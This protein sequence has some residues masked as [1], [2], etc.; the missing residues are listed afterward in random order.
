MN[1]FN[2]WLLI[3]NI[4]KKKPKPPWLWE[5]ASLARIFFPIFIP[6]CS[7]LDG[8]RPKHTVGNGTNQLSLHK[9]L[10]FL[11][12]ASTVKFIPSDRQR[13]IFHQ[14][15]IW[16]CFSHAVYRHLLKACLVPVT[17][18]DAGLQCW[19]VRTRTSLHK[20]HNIL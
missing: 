6:F 3:K 4:N 10:A 2:K 19:T 15:A 17:V 8:F 11:S 9:L 12:A 16:Q 20:A 13:D 5:L 7:Y 18:L 1:K 14:R